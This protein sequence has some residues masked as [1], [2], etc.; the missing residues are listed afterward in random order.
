MTEASADAPAFP[1]PEFIERHHATLHYGAS[2]GKRRRALGVYDADGA[3]VPLTDIRTGILSTAP[4]K[5][6]PEAG[7]V[8]VHR[9]PALF[10]G[11]G[12]PHFGHAITCSLGRLWA[13]ERLGARATLLF[14][15]RRFGWGVGAIEPLARFFGVGNPMRM[16]RGPIR[17]RR[18]F[19]ATDLFGERY[20]GRAAPLFRDWVK[21]RTP[22][23][24]E[25]R[26]GAKLYVTRGAIAKPHGRFA[27]EPVLEENLAANGFEI[28]SPEAFTLEEQAAKLQS[29]ETLV[30]SEGSAVHFFA[31]LKRPEQ[32]VFVVQ[33]RSNL[34]PLL[35]QNATAFDD[36]PV[37]FVNAI[38]R[39]WY[40]PTNKD[41]HSVAE[42]NFDV[43]RDVF[44][45]GGAIAPDG[46]WRA[47]SGEE[48][49]ASLSYSK[50]KRIP[51]ISREE[52]DRRR[53]AG[54][55]LS[56][57]PEDFV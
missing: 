12:H 46:P 3:L 21:R 52:F 28:W 31:F 55:L 39:Q 35:S 42:L 27:C 40:P 48:L 6:R 1:E 10:A 2:L 9:G 17:V 30:F 34:A 20:E 53:K 38:E 54:E 7:K 32:N 4:P 36:R 47:P 45:D 29:A 8:E 18:F 26:A 33:R 15:P 19:A 25:T 24:A 51:L 37:T 56:F 14:A 11:L 49:S 44:V 13:T 57:R 22:N 23:L 43:L 50:T 16:I 41:N 5:E